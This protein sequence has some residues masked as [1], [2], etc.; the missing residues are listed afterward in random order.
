[1]RSA[2]RVVGRVYLASL[3]L[4][5]VAF[6]V[7]AMIVEWRERRI[8]SRAESIV[9]NS[10]PDVS[11]LSAIRTELRRIYVLVDDFC[12]S[13]LEGSVPPGSAEAIEASRTR[14]LTDW[15]VYRTSPVYPHERDRWPE[16]EQLMQGLSADL[17]KVPAT[18]AAGDPHACETISNESVKPTTD[19]VDRIVADLTNLNEEQGRRL[20]REIE[21]T[22]HASVLLSW[23]LN[24][25]SL[26]LALVTGVLA[27][28][29]VRSATG[30]V[31]TRAA[32]LDEFAARVAHDIRNQLATINLAIEV[33][34]RRLGD[35]SESRG[36]LA[37]GRRSVARATEVVR[38]LLDFARAG[39]APAGGRADARTIVE[40]VVEE[41][42]GLAREHEIELRVDA[43]DA[44][45]ACAPGI[46]A[47]L[48]LNLVGNAL[49]FMV[50]RPHP[51]V[52]VRIRPLDGQVRFEVEDNGAGI[53][54]GDRSRLFEPLVR[55]RTDVP[56]L[57]LGLAT[58]RRLVEG[59][60]GEVGVESEVGRG[61][62]FW[63]TL[64]RA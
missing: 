57:G 62:R 3:A 6:I 2:S 41:L 50:D 9:T 36:A 63:F 26:V 25:L 5:V 46:L 53:S 35:A 64:P 23:L 11:R 37:G 59:H 13:A 39:T 28:R 43:T 24:G 55:G 7:S 60:G 48:I 47:S 16:L 12:D 44:E 18:V 45:V 54:S 42:G 20:A 51:L 49:K 30:A 27:L 8:E 52:T 38:A 58:V 4:T 56:G 22:R 14:L 32:E 61:A 40:G 10:A 33:A 15:R 29:I 1:M 19:T 21:N 17:Q 34:D 31:E